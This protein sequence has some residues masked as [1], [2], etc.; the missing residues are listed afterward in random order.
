MVQDLLVTTFLKKLIKKKYKI[1]VIDNFSSYQ[2]V[3]Y[4][5]KFKKF[6]I[7]HNIKFLQKNIRNLKGN[8][9]K[10]PKL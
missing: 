6:I 9:L 7:M 10:I 4:K 3:E 2:S 8:E 5:K 1:I